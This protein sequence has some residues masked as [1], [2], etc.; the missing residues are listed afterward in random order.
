MY[1]YFAYN[2]VN[3]S[4]FFKVWQNETKI[5]YIKYVKSETYLRAIVNNQSG[6]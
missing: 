1:S 3:F 2:L 5:C 6:I 4:K